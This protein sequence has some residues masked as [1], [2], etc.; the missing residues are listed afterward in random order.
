M[1]ER[2]GSDLVMID[3]ADEG[4]PALR[5]ISTPAELAAAR[6]DLGL[7]QH[8][9]ASHFRLQE[10]QLDAL[11]RGD[12]E[13]LPGTAY[14][15]ALVRA[16]S[17][18]VG[19]D[20]QPLLDAIGGYARPAELKPSM[21]AT[22]A[23]PVGGGDRSAGR[24]IRGESGTRRLP[25]LAIGGTAGLIMLAVAAASL[26][27]PEGPGTGSSDRVLSVPIPGASGPQS[28]QATAGVAAPAPLT[29]LGQPRVIGLRDTP[30]SGEAPQAP[31]QAVSPSGQLVAAAPQ[32][33]ASAEKPGSSPKPFVV[34][35]LTDAP[36]PTGAADEAPALN[37][38]VKLPPTERVRIRLSKPAWI[39][40]WHKDDQKLL[41]GTQN[42]SG[43][44]TLDGVPPMRVVIGNPNAVKL[45]FRGEDVDFSD[46][47]SRGVARF[48]LN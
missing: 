12:W 31:V 38:P 21:E 29:P 36:P 22:A 39:E 28:G 3:R 42:P 7:S 43:W 4:T 37:F 1:T 35:K 48:V 5:Q 13:E 6:E 45:Q 9:V 40:I 44:V 11:E 30:A 47:I 8:E 27:W 15:R 16:Y 18:F 24:R 33:S 46:E 10:R 34:N 2:L 26:V 20:P 25:W 32:Q 17:R 14:V 19:V 23:I 41:Y